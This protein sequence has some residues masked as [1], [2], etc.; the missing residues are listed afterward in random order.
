MLS[1]LSFVAD[2]YD[3]KARLQPA[4]ISALPMFV[5]LLLLVPEF[6]VLWG[7][8][9]GAMLFCGATTLLTHLT[10]YRGK[11]L[12]SKLFEEWDGKPSVAMLRHRDMRLSSSVKR[13]YRAFLESRV[14]MLKLASKKAE[15]R[16]PG[17]AD[18]GY[19]SAN[20]WLLTQTRDRNRFYLL[21]VENIS[22]GFHRN[23]LALKSM[24]LL[25]DL[26]AIIVAVVSVFK[27]FPEVTGA[28][29]TGAAIMCAV[30][31]IGHA[32]VFVTLVRSDWVFRSAEAYARQLLAACDHLSSSG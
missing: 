15:Q 27:L 4:L 11:S 9:S 13:R 1:S 28:L 10:R 31:A 16:F 18:D 21:F 24:A 3:R 29:P 23:L 12:E 17:Q 6:G 14:P 22:Y 8:V 26:A 7:A 25:L 32:L 19:Q 20:T 30:V 2:R 5:S